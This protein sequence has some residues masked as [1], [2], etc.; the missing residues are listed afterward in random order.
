MKKQKLDDMTRGWFIGNFEPSVL[1]TKDFEVG[2]LTH[3]KGEVWKK[4]YHKLGTEYNVLINGKMFICDT[5]INEGEI[6][7]IDPYEI[8]DPVFL[9]DCT[10]VCIKTPSVPGDKFFPQE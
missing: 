2:V 10:V 1:K 6:F 5:E 9:E 7:T 3:K 8:A 4:H